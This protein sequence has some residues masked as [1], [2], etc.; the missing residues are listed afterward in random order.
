M[1]ESEFDPAVEKAYRVTP[2]F[3]DSAL[4]DAEV[5]VRLENRW[6]WR[7]R[8]MIFIGVVGVLLVGSRIVRLQMTGATREAL[9]STFRAGEERTA[10]FGAVKEMS[11]QLGLSDVSVGILSGPYLLILFGIAATIVLGVMAVRLSKSL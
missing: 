6:R 2:E 11:Q 9:F 10:A 8:L 4:F 5:A 1:S 7:R 3:A